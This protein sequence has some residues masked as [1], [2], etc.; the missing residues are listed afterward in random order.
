MH[1]DSC[2]D[3]AVLAVLTQPD[4]RKVEDVRETPIATLSGMTPHGIYV[5]NAQVEIVEDPA[6]VGPAMARFLDIDPAAMHAPEAG[7]VPS[8]VALRLR[9]VSG[10]MWTVHS[11]APFDNDVEDIE[12]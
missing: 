2:G 11:D 10:Q 9:V 6:V 8:A 7:E 3:S 4:T 5:L 12:V 1:D